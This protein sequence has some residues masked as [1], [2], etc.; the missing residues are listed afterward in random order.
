L[1]AGAALSAAYLAVAALRPGAVGAGDCKLAA[2]LGCALGW[3]GWGAVLAA[4]VVAHLLAA[5]HALARLAVRRRADPVAFGP[6]LV[7]G[8][9]VAVVLAA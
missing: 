4:E 2:V 1:A 5:G 3:F 7:L 9:L 8:A 6:S